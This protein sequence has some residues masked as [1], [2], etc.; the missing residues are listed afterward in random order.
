VVDWSPWEQRVISLESHWEGIGNAKG[1]ADMRDDS[2]LDVGVG[3]VVT[4][5][6]GCSVQCSAPLILALWRQR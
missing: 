4:M 1:Q 5:S 2:S 6:V 3:F